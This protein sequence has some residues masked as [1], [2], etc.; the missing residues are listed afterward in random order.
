MRSVVIACLLWVGLAASA[1]A[2]DAVQYTRATLEGARAIVDSE[3]P[4]NEKLQA[5]SAL[6]KN[7]L[8]TDEMG[9]AALG[10]HWA[11][12]NPA[13]RKE[14]LVLFGK[15]LERTYVQ[16]LLFFEKPRFTYGSETRIDGETRVDT[17]IV[18][19]RDDFSVVYLLRPAGARWLATN[20]KV[21][22]VSL[23]A[24]LG[25]QLDH[26][27]SKSS[28]DDVLSLMRRKYG[29]NGGTNQ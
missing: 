23:T 25:S 10:D 16:K 17:S 19:A 18:T 4:H 2:A 5:L 22:N 20:I 3:R 6:F 21:E 27:L 11:S 28:V 13:Q 12:F 9:R 15:L 26:L 8:D 24:N 1:W 29:D 7:F 14:F